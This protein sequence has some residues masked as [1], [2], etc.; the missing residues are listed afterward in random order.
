M[1]LNHVKTIDT[2]MLNKSGL[3]ASY[4]I[5]N[6]EFALVETGAHANAEHTYQELLKIPNFDPKLVKYIITTLRSFWWR[7]LF[8]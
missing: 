8:T 4:L 5:G 3:A 2:L 1:P 6:N 7:L